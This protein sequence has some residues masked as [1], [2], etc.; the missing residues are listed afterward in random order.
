MYH[1]TGSSWTLPYN[2]GDNNLWYSSLDGIE[3]VV[4]EGLR[5][6]GINVNI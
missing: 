5:R 3:K 4:D 2:P 6:V 1:F